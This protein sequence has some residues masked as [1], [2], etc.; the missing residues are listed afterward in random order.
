M[1]V[2]WVLSDGRAGNINQILGV[3]EQLSVPFE[4]KKVVYTSLIRMPNFL[5][6]VSTIGINSET[7]HSL[8]EPYPNLVIGAGRRVFPL[9]RFIK[10]KSKGYTK[11]VQIMNPGASGF[12]DADL[13][14]LPMHDNYRGKKNNVLQ[15]IGAPHRVTA[16]RLAEEK[17]KWQSIFGEYSAPRVSVIVGGATKDF[18]FT[19]NMAHN[20]VQG[21]MN[22]NP[23]SIL[24]TTSRRTPLEVIRVLQ[25]CLPKKETY[26]YKYGDEGENPYYGLLACGDK[27]VVTGDSISMCSEACASG[28][29]VF[30]FA[31][32][33]TMGV[34]H[35]RFHEQ[36]Y[37]RGYATPL[38][39]G[40]VAFGGV[41]NVA[42][43]VAC[44]VMSLLS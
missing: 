30:I 4:V 17:Q 36:L 20:L 42:Q 14:I 22:L 25:S 26:F 5:R 35:R 43:E 16:K 31:P 3:A 39:S 2:I 41:L 8:T 21:I 24:L 37:K 18:P 10:K 11:I 44:K 33:G 13:V 28:V 15:V 7:L 34:K 38:G 40:Q 23:A 29:P 1:S 27:I 32:E 19:V 9:A 6:G 12:D